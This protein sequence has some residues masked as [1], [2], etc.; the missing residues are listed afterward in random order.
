MPKT[1][2]AVGAAVA[3]LASLLV[4]APTAQAATQTVRVV[5][6]VD[7]DTVETSRGTVRLI[8]VDTPERGR[9]GYAAAARLARRIAPA[10]STIRLGDP[11]SVRNADAYGRLLRYVNRGARD[12]GAAQ[13]RSGSWARYDSRDGYQRHPRQATYRRLDG[14]TRNHCGSRPGGTSKPRS[15][16]P[17]G[18]SRAVAPR[19]KSCPSFAPIKGNASSMIYHRPGQR[20]YKVTVPEKCFRN[21]ASARAAG[22]R[23]AKV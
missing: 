9:C 14:K 6:W 5:R 11:A 1:L 8:G 4:A 17:G 10:G 20:F 21:A 18:V 12:V 19:G 3:T 16:K 23:A 7:G 2:L 22:F 13:I 15:P